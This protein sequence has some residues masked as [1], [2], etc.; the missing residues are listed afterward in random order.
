MKKY[1][2][3]WWYVDNYF[4]LCSTSTNLKLSADTAG[5]STASTT[6]EKVKEIQVNPGGIA[7][8][9]FDMKA[10]GSGYYSEG[11][12]YVSGSAVGTL[13]ETNSALYQTYTEDIYIPTQAVVQLYVMRKTAD[14]PY[15]MY[16]NFRIY[17][18]TYSTSS[19]GVVIN[20]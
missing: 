9:S 13:R 5:S 1:E 18:D 16:R 15:V 2:N 11:R 7:R 6:Y 10:D 8:I 19:I 14:S 3:N 17:F 20:D 12:I 4:T